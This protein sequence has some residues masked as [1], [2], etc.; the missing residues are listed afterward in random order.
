VNAVSTGKTVTTAET[1]AMG[2]SIKY[3]AKTTS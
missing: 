1:K 3:R 2:C